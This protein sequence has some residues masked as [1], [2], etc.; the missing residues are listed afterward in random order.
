MKGFQVSR[1]VLTQQTRQK[2]SKLKKL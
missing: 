1:Y 2:R